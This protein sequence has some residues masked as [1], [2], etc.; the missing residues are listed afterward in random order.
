[1]LGCIVESAAALRKMTPSI[2]SQAVIDGAASSKHLSL[3][4]ITH[5]IFAGHSM[6]PYA[7]STYIKDQKL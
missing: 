7:L 4:G 3:E 1:M 6:V 2:Y 5:W